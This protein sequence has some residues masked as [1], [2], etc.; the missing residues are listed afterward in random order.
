MTHEYP[1]FVYRYK[2]GGQVIHGVPC[3]YKTVADEEE[4]KAARAKGFH[5]IPAHADP[6][7]DVDEAVEDAEGDLRPALRVEYEKLSGK[8][9]FP[10]WSYGQLLNKIEGLKS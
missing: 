8:K 1:L 4:H 9:A 6:S 5:H 3:E 10:G 7:K 2:S